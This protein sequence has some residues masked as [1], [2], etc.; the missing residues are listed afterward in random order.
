MDPEFF[1]RYNDKHETARE[2]FT[3]THTKL[4]E[5]GSNWLTKASKSCSVVAALIATI[6]FTAASSLTTW[7]VDQKSGSPFLLESHQYLQVFSV[8]AVLA[9]CFS[10]TSLALF[11]SFLTCRYERWD[12]ETDLPLKLMLNLTSLYL[13]LAATAVC[14]FA[15]YAVFAIKQKSFNQHPLFAIVLLPIYTYGVPQ[16]PLHFG[17]IKAT[18]TRRFRKVDPDR[19]EFANEG[20][21]R[22]QKHL[23]KTIKRR[24]PPSH[25][26]SQQQALGE[27]L[28]QLIH[29][30]ENGREREEA[31]SNRRTPIAMDRAPEHDD[32]GMSG[33]QKLEMP[34]KIEVRESSQ[35]LCQD[36]VSDL[37]IIAMETRGVEK[38]GVDNLE[39][40]EQ[41]DDK[42]DGELNYGF[43]EELL[44]ETLGDEKG[45]SD[46]EASNNDVNDL[47]ERLG[48]LN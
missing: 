43:R 35:D 7:G 13:S 46:I 28:K 36:D 34:I 6:A 11:L 20:F 45:R 41:Q 48:F 30:K 17:L 44:N 9:L 21:L 15:G 47:P 42:S 39:R 25:P 10:V 33:N 22:G 8:S 38:C 32:A 12:F 23:L 18:F 3:K 4:V 19:W 31:I 2:I 27:Y 26:P 16:I 37:E 1:P 14:F 5:D 24:K 40:W 29:E